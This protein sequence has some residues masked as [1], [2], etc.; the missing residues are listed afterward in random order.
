MPKKKSSKK[1][2]KVIK[3]K[4]KI[5]PKEE[6]ELEE[7]IEQTEDKI[8]DSQFREFLKPTDV[9]APVL[10]RVEI[11]QQELETT[12]SSTPTTQDNKQTTDYVTTNTPD[13]SGATQNNQGERK[14]ESEFR[15]PVL[16]QSRTSTLRP[17]FQEPQREIRTNQM[18]NPEMIEAN[19][20]EHKTTQP[21][22]AEE[23]KYREV[24]FK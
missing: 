20:I 23:K 1:K 17:A 14:Y 7:E 11:P 4:I 5:I 15:A 24:K 13:Y 3:K 18:D 8:E 12:I 21:F 9:E 22:E 6:S 19:V 10:K 16:D 2:V